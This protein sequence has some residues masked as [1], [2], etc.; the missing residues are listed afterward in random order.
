MLV[1]ALRTMG[2]ALRTPCR[3]IKNHPLIEIKSIKNII[4]SF[5][6]HLY[7]S[8]DYQKA[9]ISILIG[10]MYITHISIIINLNN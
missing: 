10:Y 7:F 8:L 2:G 6:K 3:G 1:G 5:K 4:I 9:F